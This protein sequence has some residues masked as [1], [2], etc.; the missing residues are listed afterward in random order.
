VDDANIYTHL[1]Y[2]IIISDVMLDFVHI[3]PVTWIMLMATTNLI[4]FT[5]EMIMHVSLDSLL[6]ERFI[7]YIPI[8]MMSFF[9]VFALILCK[10]VIHS[11][12]VVMMHAPYT[13]SIY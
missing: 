13:F 10:S 4:Y 11:L 5:M 2:R 9:A 12:V 3:S 8:S 1:F 7:A 6:V